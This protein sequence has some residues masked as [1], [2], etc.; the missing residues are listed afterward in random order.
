MT[1][2]RL[3]KLVKMGNPLFWSARCTFPFAYRSWSPMRFNRP[4]AV[5]RSIR[6][7]DD[8]APAHVSKCIKPI[9]ANPSAI[10]ATR[11]SSLN[12]IAALDVSAPS[13]CIR[14]ASR[15]TN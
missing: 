4:H 12:A 10:C 7:P 14:R 15:K 8:V 9:V 13:A 1:V 2:Q 3:V 6:R 5:L 11:R